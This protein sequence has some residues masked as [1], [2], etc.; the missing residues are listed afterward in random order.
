ML[1]ELMTTLIEFITNL[2]NYNFTKLYKITD[3]CMVMK[4]ILSI[5]KAIFM[6][7][8]YDLLPLFLDSKILDHF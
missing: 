5:F 7:K 8:I 3:S 4:K 6:L 2:K 1:K